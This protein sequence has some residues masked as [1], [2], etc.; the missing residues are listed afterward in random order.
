V[1]EVVRGPID[2]VMC[3]KKVVSGQLLRAGDVVGDE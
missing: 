1:Q 2:G 3:E